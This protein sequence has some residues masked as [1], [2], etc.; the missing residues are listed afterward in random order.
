MKKLTVFFLTAILLISAFSYVLASEDGTLYE[1]VRGRYSFTMPEDWQ[2]LD[3][4]RKDVFMGVKDDEETAYLALMSFPPLIGEERPEDFLT[5]T[6]ELLEPDEILKEE[7][8]ELLGQKGILLE[9]LKEVEKEE[10]EKETVQKRIYILFN[11][12]EI[13]TLTFE[14]PEDCFSS[15]EDDFDTIKESFVMNKLFGGTVFEEP[16][17][18]YSIQVPYNWGIGPDTGGPV[19][20]VGI[21][22][23]GFAFCDVTKMAKPLG[24]SDLQTIMDYWVEEIEETDHDITAAEEIDQK[25]SGEPAALLRHEYIEDTGKAHIVE[26]YI[27]IKGSYLIIISFDTKEDF[28][29][30]FV[31][32]YD[33]ILKNIEIEF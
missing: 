9:Y 5:L 25:I 23:K 32:D 11:D 2:T 30:D 1:D 18:F 8:I 24:T 12:E 22:E 6:K 4:G 21:Y 7:E 15:F 27:I 28:Y 14:S 16:E 3:D 17:G 29:E 31:N 19:Y 26:D 10:E 20:F 33:F 13:T